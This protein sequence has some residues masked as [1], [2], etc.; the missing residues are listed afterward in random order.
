MCIS[1]LKILIGDSTL[2]LMPLWNPGPD[3]IKHYSYSSQLRLKFILLI[4]VKMPTI[5]VILTYMDRINYR[6]L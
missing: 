2:S 5:V 6:F 4:N 1:D 3:V